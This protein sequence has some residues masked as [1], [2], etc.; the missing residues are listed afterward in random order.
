MIRLQH[1]VY[2]QHRVGAV[3]LLVN[4]SQWEAEERGNVLMGRW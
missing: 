2:C 4:G 1:K 3:A